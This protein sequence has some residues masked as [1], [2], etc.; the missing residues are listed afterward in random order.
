MI[1]RCLHHVYIWGYSG[2][3]MPRWARRAMAGT[4]L[5][6]AWFLGFHGFF[7]EAETQYGIGNPYGGRDANSL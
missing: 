1:E 2:K 6:R 7:A 3:H 5:H 4:G